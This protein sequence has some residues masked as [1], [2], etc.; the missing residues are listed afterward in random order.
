MLMKKYDFDTVISRKGTGSLKW[1][2]MEP[3][4]CPEDVIPFSVAD[5]EFKNM[6]E[7][8]GGLKAFLDTNIL[9]YSNPTDEY[10]DAVCGWLKRRHNWIIS[11]EWILDTPGIINAFFTAVNAFTEPG[12]GVLLT[13]PVYYPMY[14]AVERNGRNIVSSPLINDNGVYHIDFEDFQA[15]AKDPKT[16]LFILCSPHNP[17]SR[18]WTRE[19]LERLGRICIDNGVVIC[20]DEIHNDLIMPGYEHTVF[21]SI[22]EEFARHSL[23]CTA[24]SKTFNLAGLQTS[25]II[26]PD[27]ELRE[28]FLAE[29]LKHEGNPKCNILGLEGCRLAYTNGDKRLEQALAIINTNR[30]MVVDFLGEEFPAVKVTPLEGTYLLWMD[31]RPL[32]I[33]AKE[34]ARILREEAHLFFDDGFIFGEQGTGFERWNLACPTSYIAPALERLKVALEKHI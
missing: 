3:Y 28:R 1:K 31:F 33:E 17:S 10:K 9:G 7:I 18:V 29:I 25:N 4:N 30:K 24:P 14:M 13:T 5:M 22:S 6:P 21:G 15:K 19:E 16:K 12:D 27:K 8:V 32:G 20:S 11:P 23:V 34:L 2:E 26:I